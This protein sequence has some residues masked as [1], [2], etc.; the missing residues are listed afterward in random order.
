VSFYLACV[1]ERKA[2]LQLLFE[3]ARP[4]LPAVA[5]IFRELNRVM[6]PRDGEGPGDGE[7]E[8]ARGKGGAE[9][10]LQDR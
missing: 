9:T 4:R 8:A 3:E 2:A 7:E 10:T 1:V 5:R 6:F